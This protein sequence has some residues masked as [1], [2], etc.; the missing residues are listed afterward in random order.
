[1]RL[2]I[3]KIKEEFQYKLAEEID[4]EKVAQSKAFIK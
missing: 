2:Q 1:M 3:E 4:E